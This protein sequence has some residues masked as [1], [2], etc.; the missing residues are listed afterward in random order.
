MQQ[1]LTESSTHVSENSQQ[2][3]GFNHHLLPAP[4]HS[5]MFKLVCSPS[6]MI[7]ISICLKQHNHKF[8]KF[9]AKSE[10]LIKKES[11]H[12]L[13]S[14]HTHPIAS[15]HALPPSPVTQPPGLRPPQAG[16]FRRSSHRTT[17]R[18]RLRP[19]SCEMR[20]AR[21]CA[22]T[23][24]RAW[25]STRRRPSQPSCIMQTPK[26]PCCGLSERL[27]P[28]W[29]RLMAGW[30]TRPGCVPPRSGLC[31]FSCF[32]TLFFEILQRAQ[33]LLLRMGLP[34]GASWWWNR[35][36]QNCIGVFLPAE[37]SC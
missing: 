1:Q 37:M 26:P 10:F 24:P 5:C 30:R 16:S 3:P 28:S 13:Y 27:P 35:G 18:G 15:L 36:Q 2:L 7:P 14:P 19:S 29:E 22:P 4:P 21:S 32:P 25:P 6:I 17:S 34:G 11:H 8:I 20:T 23:K 12:S 9:F 31:L 33:F